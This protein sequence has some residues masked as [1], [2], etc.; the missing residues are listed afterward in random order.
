MGDGTRIGLTMSTKEALSWEWTR[1]A[2]DLTKAYLESDALKIAHN[3]AYDV[4]RLQRAGVAVKGPLWCTMLAQQEIDPDAPGYS[5][6]EVASFWLDLTRWKHLGNPASKP[7][8]PKE[9][10][11]KREFQCAECGGTSTTGTGV[12]DERIC[13]SCV[14]IDYGRSL[15]RWESLAALYNRRDA[16]HLLGIQRE[17]ERALR[18][19]GRLSWFRE[20]MA[21]LLNVLIPMKDSGIRVDSKERQRIFNRY[22][23]M[24]TYALA[25][26]TRQTGVEVPRSNPALRKLIY[27]EWKLPR[28]YK[29]ARKGEPRKLTLDAE[30]VGNLAQMVTGRRRRAL[31]ALMRVRRAGKWR[32]TYARIGDRVYPA[33]SPSTKDS[34][35][36]GR[37]FGAIASTGRIIAR[38]DSASH[39]PP[40][41]Q[42]PKRL[43][44][45]FVPD[46]GV[47]VQAD[48]GSQE[49]RITAYLCGDEALIEA[50]EKGIDI[51]ERNRRAYGVDRTRAKNL[52]YGCVFGGSGRALQRALRQVGYFTS[53][54]ECR[55][56]VDITKGLYPGVF[57]WHETVLAQAKRQRYLQNPFGR[58][59]YFYDPN[60]LYNEV[61]NFPVQSTGADILWHILGDVDELARS[62]GGALRILVHDSVVLDIPS[63]RVE[64]CVVRLRE[65]M[66]REWPM[67]APG[68]RVPVDIEVGPSWGSL[69]KVEKNAAG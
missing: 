36:G 8:P 55:S 47:F 11:W 39:T 38:G 19:I 44:G 14:R 66:E 22:D 28:Q 61:L 41:Q 6:E 64:E 59:R 16:Y 42:I 69:K 43:R 30:A 45:M 54:E 18:K 33:Y 48:Y 50:I 21:L 37:R 68:F 32:E 24:Y 53:L 15:T 25:Q 34:A 62:L 13:S 63:A 27:D 26:W 57:S 46:E 5:L 9:K 10:T 3:A 67:I 1:K 35:E 23:R 51:H 29:E 52:F 49:L 56:F 60:S 7:K 2:F 4:P 17:Q 20:E 65:T 58:R 12:R 40:I 31:S